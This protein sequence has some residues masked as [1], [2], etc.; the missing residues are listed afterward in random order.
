MTDSSIVNGEPLSVTPVADDITMID[1]GMARQREL[2]AVY[3]IAAG[4]P[5]LIETGPGA[6]GPLVHR[7]L[8][9]LG[10]GPD[11]LA[12]VVVTHIHI[13]HAG[14]AG[15]IL[16]RFPRAMLWVHEVGAPHLVDPT[17]L[18]A[19]TARTYGPE[20]MRSFYGETLPVASERIRAVSGGDRIGLGDRSLE[21]LHTP[22]HASH[23]VSL[24]DDASGAMFTG[25][26]IGSHL[27]WADCYRPAL[28]PPDVDVEQALASIERMSATAPRLLL[29]SHYGPVARAD[30]GFDRG[31][32]RIRAWSET[33]RRELEGR[34]ERD[35][36]E[37]VP[38]L[39]EQARVEYEL[40]SGQPF[41]LA[42]YDA[43]GSI[44][45]N[46]HGLARYWRKRWERAGAQPS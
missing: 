10:I 29:T 33:V 14:G 27:P 7:V 35:P 8:D 2:N 9:E 18:V 38:I 11:D 31:A 37:L 21:V 19:S 42:R 17:R 36:A 39:R 5:V 20:R 12:H 4:E 26:S 22:G 3:L 1:T 41:D 32:R 34:A 40:D 6:D 28:P 44:A 46:A 24:L 25:E 30:E 15:P 45:M 43:I 13:D 23:H 16:D